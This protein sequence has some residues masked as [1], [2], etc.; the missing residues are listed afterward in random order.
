MLALYQDLAGENMTYKELK[1]YVEK[2]NFSEK[3]YICNFFTC[4]T[5]KMKKAKISIVKNIFGKFVV[6]K[7]LDYEYNKVADVQTFFEK[8]LAA[9]YAWNLF[10][11]DNRDTCPYLEKD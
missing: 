6:T 4:N 8:D 2:N 11:G 5:E 9:D 7:W 3:I 1:N 10:V